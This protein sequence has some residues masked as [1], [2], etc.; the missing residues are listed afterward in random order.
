MQLIKNYK[1]GV[2]KG[3]K[4]CSVEEATKLEIEDLNLED[5]YKELGCFIDGYTQQ[6]PKPKPKKPKQIKR[7]ET[8]QQQE[9]W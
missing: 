5:V 9:L 8:I 6:K 1:I 3:I 4:Y 2:G 7:Y